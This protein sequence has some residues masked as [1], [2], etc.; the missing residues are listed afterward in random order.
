MRRRLSYLRR[1]RRQGMQGPLPGAGAAA[2]HSQRAAG[3]T[4]RSG[5]AACLRLEHAIDA[6]TVRMEYADEPQ[7]IMGMHVHMRCV[8]FL[9]RGMT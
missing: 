3:E 1:A 9:Q 6:D 8:A 2:T 7:G 4:T 5:A